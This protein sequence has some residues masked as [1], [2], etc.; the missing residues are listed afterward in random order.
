MKLVLAMPLALLAV[1]AAAADV[2]FSRYRFDAG[3]EAPKLFYD[4]YRPIESGSQAEVAIVLIHGWG[5]Y[6]RTLLTKP[7]IGN[8]G[9]ERKW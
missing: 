7:L 2:P 6:V 5:G 3:K 9:C 1:T 8:S 4:A